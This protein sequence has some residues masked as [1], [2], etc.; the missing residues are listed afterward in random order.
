MKTIKKELFCKNIKEKLL[1]EKNQQEDLLNESQQ[2]KKREK[3]IPD[4]E[5]DEKANKKELRDKEKQL[6]LELNNLDKEKQ[7]I[8]RPYFAQAADEYIKEKYQKEEQALQEKIQTYTQQVAKYNKKNLLTRI[9]SDLIKNTQAKLKKEYTA[10]QQTQQNLNNN[11]RIDRQ[12]LSFAGYYD[13]VDIEVRKR[14]YQLAIKQEPKLAKELEKIE[15]RLEAIRKEK[16][17]ITKELDHF[18]SQE[19]K[20]YQMNKEKDKNKGK[21]MGLSL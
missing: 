2:T 17:K 20:V 12:K 11:K 18:R 16:V 4:I 8:V 21:D 3:E 7:Q 5:K 10:I 1:Q 6:S 9:A 14:C 13:K 19:R 15:N